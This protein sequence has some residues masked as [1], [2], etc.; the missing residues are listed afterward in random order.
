MSIVNFWAAV[1]RL[2]SKCMKEVEQICAS[3]LWS[4]PDLRTTGAKVAWEVICKPKLEGG[5]GIR[6]L[7]EVNVVYGLKLIWRMLT[8]DSL[9]GQWIRVYLLKK[10]SFWEIKST[11][12][13]GSWMWRK[14][15]KLRVIAKDFYKMEI[16]NGRHISFWYDNWS[17]MGVLSVLLGDRGMIDLGIRKEASLEEA[18]LSIRRRRLHLTEILNNVERS[19]DLVRDMLC[20]DRKDCSLWKGKSGYMPHFSMQ[21]IG[22]VYLWMIQKPI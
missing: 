4:G 7:K 3:F 11:T 1:F 9:W 21:E 20:D 10:R 19:L 18:V 17:E 15:L 8:G 2:P 16:G 13:T 12:Q 5:L 6:M 22:F 14:M